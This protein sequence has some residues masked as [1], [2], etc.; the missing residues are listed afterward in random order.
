[1]GKGSDVTLTRYFPLRIRVFNGV[2]FFIAYEGC[3]TPVF[4]AGFSNPVFLFVL[5]QRLNTD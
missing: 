4:R 2:T 5:F 3:G 1:M